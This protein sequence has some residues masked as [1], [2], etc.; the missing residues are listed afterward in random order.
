V[1]KATR[2]TAAMI[3]VEPV[4]AT[5]GQGV[6]GGAKT[7]SSVCLSCHIFRLS[8][9][10]FVSGLSEVMAV[11]GIVVDFNGAAGIAILG[12]W[13]LNGIFN[14]HTGQ[15]LGLTSVTNTDFNYESNQKPN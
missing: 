5:T 4:A 12:G 8:P 9:V 14:L 1:K 6:T 11:S 15:P 7:F 10:G 13:Q 2:T 3:A